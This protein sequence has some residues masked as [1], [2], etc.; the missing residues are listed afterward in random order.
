MA[1]ATKSCQVSCPDCGQSFLVEVASD[2]DHLRL[3]CP[4]CSERLLLPSVAFRP[5]DRTP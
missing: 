5:D 4:H 2:T 3:E 1:V